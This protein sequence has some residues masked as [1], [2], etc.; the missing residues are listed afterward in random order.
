VAATLE[1]AGAA[2]LDPVAQLPHLS[3]LVVDF[4]QRQLTQTARPKST[5]A[6]CCHHPAQPQFCFN[7]NQPKN[8]ARQRAA[9]SRTYY[10]H[11]SNWQ[12]SRFAFET[13]NGR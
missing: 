4:Q 3:A 12:Q 5:I 10:L 1:R 11:R 8:V 9:K 13:L 6:P 2:Q 7:K